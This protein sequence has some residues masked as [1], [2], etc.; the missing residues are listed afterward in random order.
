MNRLR[1]AVSLVI[2]ACL[3][4]ASLLCAKGI[5]ES[6]IYRQAG[7]WLSDEPRIYTSRLTDEQRDSL[8]GALRE[9]AAEHGLAAIGTAT[10]LQSSGATVYT[11][12][13]LATP[14]SNVSIDPFAVLGETVLDG[15]LVERLASSGPDAYAGF[16]NNVHERLAELP[17]VR[18]GAY[19]CV[20]NLSS[21]DDL[22]SSVVLLGVDEA[23]LRSTLSAASAAT[24]VSADDLTTRMSGSSQE[25]GLLYLFSAGALVLLAAVLCLLMVTQALLALKELGVHLMLGWSKADFVMGAFSA[26]FS[27]VLLVPL[28]CLA[29][30]PLILEGFS[31]GPE[32]VG[33]AFAAMLPALF[34]V[35]V[36]MGVAMLPLVTARPV[37][38]ICGRYSRRGFYV[39]ATSVFVACLVA[40]FGGCLYID[41]PLSMYSDLARAR[42]AWAEH[43]SWS[44]PRDFRLDGAR[45]TGNPMTLADKTYAWYAE[46]EHDDGVYLVKADYFRESTIRAYLDEGPYPEPF[47]YLAAS[48]S[49][50]STI[51]IEL[52]EE[53]LALAEAGTRIYLLPGSL[54]AQEAEALERFL[55]AVR[56]P[57]D[58]N[59]VTPFM[60]EPS[61]RFSTYDASRELFTWSADPD[62]PAAAPG[63]VIAVVTA[64]NMV[65]FE[66][67]SLV[68]SGHENCY[69]KLAPEAAARLLDDAG[70]ASLGGSVTLRFATVG[71]YVDGLQKSLEDLFA[72]F[73]V[74]LAMFVVTIAVMVACLVA[75]VNRMRAQDV[76]V[77]WVLGF[78]AWDTYRTEVLLVNVPVVLGICLSAAVG[79]NAGLIV[80]AAVLVV[81]NAALLTAARRGSASMVLET[82]SK[83]Q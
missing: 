38:A 47:R 69:V 55:V 62:E 50:L 13:A 19:F 64:N 58:S 15:A 30:T 4:V 67:E 59:I 45:F 44:V 5:L 2:I 37:D 70:E 81:S 9:A 43:E 11:F 6:L 42:S 25:M 31:L 63:F 29:D 83:E 46:H 52:S 79:S 18:S 32:V 61:Y 24:G 8:V 82:V 41:Q 26:Q 21:G 33:F 34:A 12:S 57:V 72:L 1:S 48:P 16:G 40:V 23:G 73:A 54:D 76:A 49:Y 68:A 27:Q 75:A 17:S 60:E 20:Q 78:G 53:E 3:S 77:R 39:L 28:V 74:A 14:G 36:A 71:S 80:G 51:G 35:L 65:P 56:R 66:S 7:S 22:G 10:E